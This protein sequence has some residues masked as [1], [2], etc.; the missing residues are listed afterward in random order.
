[1]LNVA[2]FSQG[3]IDLRT[4]YQDGVK[5]IEKYL[6]N[7]YVLLFIGPYTVWH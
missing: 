5:K 2:V 6:D 4:G 3:H 1:M 7:C